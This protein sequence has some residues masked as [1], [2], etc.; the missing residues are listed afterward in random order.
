MSAKY[1]TL[2]LFAIAYSTALLYAGYRWGA[3]V[4]VQVANLKATG[5]EISAAAR[6]VDNTIKS[7]AARAV[8]NTIKKG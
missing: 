5:Q 2:V 8:D 3:R 7:A 4:A 6:A 1:V